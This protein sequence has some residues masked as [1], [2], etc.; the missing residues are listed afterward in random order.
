MPVFI[1]EK[2]KRINQKE[3][4]LI[5]KQIMKMAFE[6]QNDLGRFYD[7]KVYN[8]ELSYMATK[9]GFDVQN[10]VAICIS[11]QNYYKK[12]YI[13]L[14]I[15]HSC[16]YELKTVNNIAGIHRKQLI[17]YLLLLNV[18]HGK[19]IN[20]RTP[21][22]E[23]EF[24]STTLNTEERMKYKLD[25]NLF[26]NVNDS[27]NQ[28][29]NIVHNLLNDWGVFLNLDLY[30]EAIIHLLGGKEKVITSID[31]LRKN[32]IIGQQKIYKLDEKTAI[33][34]SALTRYFQ[35]YET[36]IRRLLN[37]SKLEAIHWLNFNQRNI[38][39]KTINNK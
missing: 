11:H 30:R 20:F 9:M 21:S 34:F 7:E 31:V 14:L 28:F 18:S 32:R 33:H 37:H 5:D 4:Y 24:V 22:V 27:T 13:D 6:L 12:Y 26:L 16:V 38:S 35:S 3:F 8:H 15:N 29:L 1:K 23:Y 36:N 19:L 17:N 39:I 10:E 25:I 2:I